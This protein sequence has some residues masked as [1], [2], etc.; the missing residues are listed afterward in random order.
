[1]RT[2]TPEWMLP[3]LCPTVAGAAHPTVAEAAH[4]RSG[5]WDWLFGPRIEDVTGEQHHKFD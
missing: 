5:S 3:P 2:Q 1:M 4:S